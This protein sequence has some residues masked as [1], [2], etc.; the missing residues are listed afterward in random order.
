MSEITVKPKS[1]LYI[2]P[3]NFLLIVDTV[4]DNSNWPE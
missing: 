2:G 4:H 3:V 1:N